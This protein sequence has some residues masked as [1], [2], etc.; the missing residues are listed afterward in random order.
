MMGTDVSLHPELKKRLEP[1]PL[2]LWVRHPLIVDLY[3]E[4]LADHLNARFD[5]KLAELERHEKA[6]NWDLWIFVH[7]RPY[8]L[9][10]LMEALDRG[11]ELTTDLLEQVW[12]DC[13]GPWINREVWLDLFQQVDC[14]AIAELPEKL[15]IYRGTVEDDE[16]G[17][18]W[19]TN[20]ATAQFFADRFD[21][22]GVVKTAVIHR[23]SVLF[24]TE[25]RGEYE[26]IYDP[27]EG[28][29]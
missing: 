26:V 13:E 5:W 3:H 16:E 29:H 9:D 27:N 21:K 2:G 6:G 18:S 20:E 23:R 24:Y 7:A 14:P 8:R 28:E 22:G 17:I 11:A 19:T 25:A 12:V 15:V 1:G 4:Q 10:A